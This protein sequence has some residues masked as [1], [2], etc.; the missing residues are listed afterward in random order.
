MEFQNRRKTLLVIF[1]IWGFCLGI[2]GFIYGA[3]TVRDAEHHLFHTTLDAVVETFPYSFFDELHES[4]EFIKDWRMYIGNRP[5]K[6]LRPSRHEG[7]GVVV[8]DAFALQP[9]L[10]L[11]SGLF[12]NRGS[13]VR[14]IDNNGI[15]VEQWET[16]YSKIWP[17]PVHLRD[18]PFNDWFVDIHGLV[19]LPD[20]SI[21]FNF[22]YLGLSRVD[23]CGN[24]MWKVPRETHHAVF[25]ADDNT[26]WVPARRFHNERSTLFPNL[27]PPFYEDTL[28]QVSLNGEVLREISVLGLVYEN[29]MEGLLQTGKRYTKVRFIDPL[30]LNDVDVLSPKQAA[31]FESLDAGVVM[32]SMRFPNLVLIFEPDSGKIIWHQNG[33]WIRQHDPDFRDDGQISVYD[34]RG[35]EEDEGLFGD[36][37]ILLIDP[38][39]RRT[40]DAYPYDEVNRFFAP[41]RGRHQNLDNG[42]TLVVD[43]TGGQ[44]LEIAKNGRTVWS[45]LNKYDQ[46]TVGKIQEAT[47]YSNGYLDQHPKACNQSADKKT[48]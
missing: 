9:G 29:K 39:T 11:I 32:I 6:H 47:R 23:R 12:D 2:I 20:Y 17:D 18:V 30:H 4:I 27:V 26:L 40:R 10:T 44:I 25:L 5:T 22:E 48:D 1:L 35:A 43:T 34:N 21:V 16:R 37:R 19:L 31:A 41:T 42:N 8:N 3:A 15:I 36:T 28:L 33:P 7:R 24:V 38:I 13:S 45:Y 14:L 46:N